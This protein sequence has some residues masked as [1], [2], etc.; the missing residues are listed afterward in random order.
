MALGN[1]GKNRIRRHQLRW[2]AMGIGGSL[3]LGAATGDPAAM[4][5]RWGQTLE[6][7]LKAS[8]AKVLAQT[9]HERYGRAVD[10]D[11]L[12]IEL[13]GELSRILYFGDDDHL[14]RVWINFG[15]PGEKYWEANFGLEEAIAK[16]GELKRKIGREI[17]VRQCDEPELH[18]VDDEGGRKLDPGFRRDR[19]VWSCEYESGPT[20]LLIT[21]RRL[22]DREGKRFD[23]T[24][25]ASAWKAVEIF[26]R[27]HDP[28]P[29][30]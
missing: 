30:F 27:D 23:V 28:H 9:R 13:G 11:R 18:Y 5:L 24:Y 21:L 20:R 16:Y 1:L 7:S 2:V 8:D 3:A 26:R 25:D 12:P 4:G 14:L 22:G 17:A 19:A 6:G 29:R 15:H 10:F